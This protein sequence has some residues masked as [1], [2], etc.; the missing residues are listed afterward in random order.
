MA[1]LS[2]SGR[3]SAGSTLSFGN[4][5]RCRDRYGSIRT[6]V[7]P[8]VISQPAVP[9]YF[10]STTP[11]SDCAIS[12]HANAVLTTR[13]R[14]VRRSGMLWLLHEA[15]LPTGAPALETVGAMHVT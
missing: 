2:N 10:S 6:T 11:R 9:R 1:A 14:T 7:R 5:L 15:T 8:S 3:L 4:T 13:V 12:G